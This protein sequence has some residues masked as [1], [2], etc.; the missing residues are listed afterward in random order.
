MKQR[1]ANY[2]EWE[3]YLN[4]MYEISIDN[5]EDMILRSVELLSDNI[6]FESI[7]H[8]VYKEWP[9]SISVNLSNRSCNRQA[10]LGQAACSYNHKGNELT[11]RQAWSRLTGIQR[12]QANLIADKFIKKYERENSELYKNMGEP[13]L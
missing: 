11:T 8:K 13:L 2:L 4:G 6:Y 7:L 3:D 1:Y 5:D 12:Y 10:W 9:I